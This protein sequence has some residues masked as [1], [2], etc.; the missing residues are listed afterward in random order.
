M[1]KSGRLFARIH[2]KTKRH[3]KMGPKSWALV[4]SL[5]SFASAILTPDD[6]ARILQLSASLGVDVEMTRQIFAATREEF[7]REMSSS[8]AE[9]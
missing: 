3:R 2:K 8:G 1:Q 9:W 7:S 6:E 5:C 4:L